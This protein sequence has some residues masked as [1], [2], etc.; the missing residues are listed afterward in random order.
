M[1]DKEIES[2]NKYK[3]K[4]PNSVDNR[5]KSS[6]KWSP[7]KEPVI[8]NPSDW[9]AARTG[10][11]V[12]LE[13]DAPRRKTSNYELES[14]AP[15]RKTRN[16][17]STIHT[18]KIASGPKFSSFSTKQKEPEDTKYWDFPSLTESISGKKDA[19]PPESKVQK[20][21]KNWLKDIKEANAERDKKKETPNT[22][23]V[24]LGK[25]MGE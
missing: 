2:R 4:R 25:S 12:K 8:R 9:F 21:T 1:T 3:V 22:G 11:P 5:K 14:D 18:P 17:E 13:P 24:V 23:M 7:K 10:K 15:R 19:T 6:K 20:P 16:Y